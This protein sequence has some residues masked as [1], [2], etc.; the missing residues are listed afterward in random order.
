MFTGF[1][2]LGGVAIGSLGVIG[3]GKMKK[4]KNETEQSDIQEDNA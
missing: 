1:G 3:A 4:K 2:L